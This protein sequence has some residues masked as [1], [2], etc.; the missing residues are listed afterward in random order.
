MCCP[1]FTL[2]NNKHYISDE[3]VGYVL[4]LKMM[5]LEHNGHILVVAA[6]QATGFTNLVYSGG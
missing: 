1:S 5:T 6:V 4:L 2:F 3:V